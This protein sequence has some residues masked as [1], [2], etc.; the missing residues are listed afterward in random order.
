MQHQILSFLKVNCI[1]ESETISMNFSK[2]VTLKFI[3]LF[4]ALNRYFTHLFCKL[5]NIFKNITI[6][7][8]I[9]SVH[10]REI[11]DSRGNPT[12]EVDVLTESGFFGRAAVPSGASTCEREALE[13]RDGENSL[14]T[15]CKDRLIRSYVSIPVI[16][17][18]QLTPFVF[19]CNSMYYSA[20]LFH[21]LPIF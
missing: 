18:R 10:A 5:H 14:S 11:L 15:I 3:G 21:L 9:V 4:C 8:Q 12:V 13:L 2:S 17:C 1:I 6:M 7:S 19:S 16:H 20:I